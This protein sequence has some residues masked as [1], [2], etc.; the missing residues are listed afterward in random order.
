MKPLV[1]I[2]AGLFVMFGLPD[3]SHFRDWVTVTVPVVQPSEVDRVVAVYD[4]NGRRH[5]SDVRAAI[6]DLNA[7]GIAADF[8]EVGGTD[9]DGVVA[10]KYKLA[11]SAAV[12]HG[13]PCV[14]YLA[15]GQ[16][17]RVVTEGSKEAVM[18]AVK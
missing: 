5:S 15:G 7:A 3:L 12:K 8:Y 9:G 14:V 4:H 10:E 13:M 2:A 18:E 17:L 1:L 16:V 11:E 6:G